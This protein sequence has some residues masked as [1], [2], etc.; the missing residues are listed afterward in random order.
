MRRSW[1]RAFS[2]KVG[3]E[4]ESISKAFKIA[5]SLKGNLLY[6]PM[7][8][9]FQIR[10][11]RRYRCRF[12]RAQLRFENFAATDGQSFLCDLFVRP[13]LRSLDQ[14]LSEERVRT[15]SNIFNTRRR[16]LEAGAA[17]P[18]PVCLLSNSIV[19]LTRGGAR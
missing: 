18:T 14:C 1:S 8:E 11:F 3:F 15:S 2:L 13:S 17:V 10:Y 6:V 5:D 12:L 16:F 4:F 19:R 9:T 7:R